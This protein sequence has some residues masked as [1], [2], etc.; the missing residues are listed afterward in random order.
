MYSKTP[1]PLLLNE[2]T[3]KFHPPPLQYFYKECGLPSTQF[4]L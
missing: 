3:L 4:Y 2:H 1:P